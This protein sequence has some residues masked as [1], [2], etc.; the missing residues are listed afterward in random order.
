VHQDDLDEPLDATEE[1]HSLVRVHRHFN[2]VAGMS[3]P[4]PVGILPDGH[5]FVECFVHGTQ[6]NRL[7]RK[8]WLPRTEKLS[9]VLRS[10]GRFLRHVHDIDGHHDEEIVPA[11]MAADIGDFIEGPLAAA[12]L[13]APA[14]T[15]RAL[16]GA[17]RDPVPA[18][19]ATLHGDF[20]PVN[21][22]VRPSGGLVGFDLGLR[23]VSVVERDLARFIAMMSTDR[24][25]LISPYAVPLERFRRAMIRALMDGYGDRRSHPA[26]LQLALVDELLRR[27]TTRHALSQG[28]GGHARAARFMLKKRFT[29]LLDEA[30]APVMTS[31]PGPLTA[32]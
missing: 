6:V 2:G 32:A 11:A 19:T 20:A 7:L 31:A 30:C 12:G 8:T 22:I 4:A 13:Q 23:T 25:F 26:V 1:F 15:R 24:P 21:F 27:W 28:G 10:C 16:E 5:G 14:A 18:V 9:D 3:V 29:A 17:S